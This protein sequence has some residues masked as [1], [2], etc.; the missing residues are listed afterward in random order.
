MVP[1]FWVLM[2]A[3]YTWMSLYIGWSASMLILHKVGLLKL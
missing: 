3:F 2:L 1:L